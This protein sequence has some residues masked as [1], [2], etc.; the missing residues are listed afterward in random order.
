MV[1]EYRDSINL[2]K[3]EVSRRDLKLSGD[4][5]YK[6]SIEGFREIESAIESGWRLP[7]KEEFKY[8][9]SIWKDLD[10]LSLASNSDYWIYGEPVDHPYNPVWELYPSVG[11]SVL[12]LD[13]VM[14]IKDQSLRIRLVK[15]L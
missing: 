6:F 7:T 4:G 5:T 2:G 9:H 14:S 1:N 13:F 3:I 11:V 12:T 8:I 10:G 15:D